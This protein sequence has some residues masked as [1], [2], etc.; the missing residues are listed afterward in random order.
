M[1]VYLLTLGCK[2]NQHESR[3]AKEQLLSYGHEVTK[4]LGDAGLILVNTCSVTHIAD[5]KSRQMISRARNANTYAKLIITGCMPENDEVE[6]PQIEGA[7]IVY[8]KDLPEFLKAYQLSEGREDVPWGLPEE[9]VRRTLLV[10]N[11]CKQ[12]CSYCKIPYLRLDHYCVPVSQILVEARKSLESGVKEFVLTGINL[13]TYDDHGQHF[14]DLLC[15][16]MEI[17]GSFRVRLG[18]I[19]PNLVTEELLEL[20]EKQTRLVPHLH[21]PLQGSTDRLLSMMNRRYSLMD[22]LALLE[23]IRALSRRVLVT[24]DLIIGFPS[25]TDEEFSQ[26]RKLVESGCF[27]DVHVFPFSPRKGTVAYGLP[28]RV[29]PEVQRERVRIAMQAVKEAKVKMLEELI[30]TEMTLLTEEGKQGYVYGF[31]EQYIKVR[32]PQE[33]T[34]QLNQFVKVIPRSVFRGGNQVGLE[35]S[36]STTP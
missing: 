15:R 24:T 23:R 7:Q 30:G 22:Y 3:L 6:T 12:F 1:K 20:L 18:S 19:E 26:T 9:R 2:V 10:Q 25:E 8:K 31:S 27:L 29:S 16:I 17:L 28:G 11:G 5:R 21:I 14:T 36:L 4:S 13:G 34:V 32:I 35:A 33:P